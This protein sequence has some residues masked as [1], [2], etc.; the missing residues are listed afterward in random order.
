MANGRAPWVSRGRMT[1]NLVDRDGGATRFTATRCDLVFGSN[2]QL[3]SVAE[4]YAAGDGAGRFA[5]DFVRVWDEV[6]ILDRDDV[7]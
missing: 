3:R 2:S 5:K 1:F 4:V 6:M 7:R